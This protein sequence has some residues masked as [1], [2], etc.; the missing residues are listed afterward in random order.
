MKI[1]ETAG[2]SPVTNRPEPAEAQSKQVMRCSM[3]QVNEVKEK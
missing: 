3:E 2:T 1:K